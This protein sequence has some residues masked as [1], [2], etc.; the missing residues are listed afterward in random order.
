MLE[1]IGENVN[2]NFVLKVPSRQTVHNLVNKLRTMGLLM[3]KEQKHKCQVLTEEKL[4][5]IVARLEHAPRKSQ[6]V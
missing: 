3:D 5:V 6:K 4:G 1:S 2:V